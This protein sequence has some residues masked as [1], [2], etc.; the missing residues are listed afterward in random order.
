MCL[1]VL[2]CTSREGEVEYRGGIVRWGIDGEGQLRMR[3]VI[4]GIEADGGS[5]IGGFLRGL[6]AVVVVFFKG[7]LKKLSR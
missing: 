4:C 5:G 1:R 3:P 6:R 7:L 2:F